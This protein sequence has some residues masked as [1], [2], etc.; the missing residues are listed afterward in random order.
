M[1]YYPTRRATPAPRPDSNAY[2]YIGLKQSHTVFGEA[3]DLFLT[4]MNRNVLQRLA[5][6]CRRLGDRIQCLQGI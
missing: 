3:A 2:R 4:E 5:H 1:G 6:L